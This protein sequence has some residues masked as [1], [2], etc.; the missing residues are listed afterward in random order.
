M[1]RNSQEFGLRISFCPNSLPIPIAVKQG[2]LCKYVGSWAHSVSLFDGHANRFISFIPLGEYMY[3]VEI[4]L[5]IA[6]IRCFVRRF[7]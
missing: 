3:A 1:V 4:S 6:N 5:F 2:Y 7:Q